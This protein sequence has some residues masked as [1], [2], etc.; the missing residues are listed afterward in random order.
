LSSAQKPDSNIAAINS[1]TR[2]I[3]QRFNVL[4]THHAHNI[5]H[6]HHKPACN[7][8][9]PYPTVVTALSL[10][11]SLV[12]YACTHMLTHKHTAWLSSLIPHLHLLVL[13]PLQYK[14]KKEYYKEEKHEEAEVRQHP[15]QGFLQPSYSSYH[16]LPQAPQRTPVQPRLCLCSETVTFAE[17]RSATLFS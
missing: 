10:L 15:Q 14:P 2:P 5:S 17:S 16:N 1:T 7:N 9:T 4:L 11:W 12:A 3:S 8:S 13:V 6:L